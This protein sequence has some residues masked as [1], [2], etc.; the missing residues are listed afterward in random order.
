[1]QKTQGGERILRNRGLP[2]WLSGKESACQCS[3]HRFDSWIQKIPWKRKWQSTPYLENPMTEEA[4]GLQSTGS[5][6]IGH[7]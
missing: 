7:N 1:M 5:Q 6:R 3:R 4:G 2:W